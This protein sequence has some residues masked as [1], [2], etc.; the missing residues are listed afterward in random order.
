MSEITG[1]RTWGTGA[2]QKAGLPDL[3]EPASFGVPVIIGTYGRPDRR[4]DPDLAPRWLWLV[5][6]AARA[7][8]MDSIA[9]N[10]R[11]FDGP[12]T[13]RQVRLEDAPGEDQ[14][15]NSAIRAGLLTVT[16]YLDAEWADF[17]RERVDPE[18]QRLYLHRRRMDK[19]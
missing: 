15:T 7:R 13:V 1:P 18:A 14:V 12:G 17:S 10:D 6:L 2:T 8:G 11:L 5:W 9:V 4:V 3:M 16:A 19:L